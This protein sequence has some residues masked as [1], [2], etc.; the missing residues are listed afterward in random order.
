MNSKM[1]IITIYFA[2]IY[3]RKLLHEPV[4]KMA[5][6]TK[7]SIQQRKCFKGQVLVLYT[8]NEI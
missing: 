7:S 1:E 4:F 8:F 3:E 6:V 2:K 5:T